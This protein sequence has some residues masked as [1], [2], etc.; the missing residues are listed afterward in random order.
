MKSTTKAP[1]RAK[2]AISPVPMRD[3]RLA[4]R[5]LCFYELPEPERSRA[6]NAWV[7]SAGTPKRNA[8][9]KKRL[10]DFL[11]LMVDIAKKLTPRQR[12][13]ARALGNAILRK[14]SRTRATRSRGAASP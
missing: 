12:A 14:A 1:G 7:N 8:A 11:D 13:A 5:L 9:R 10:R 6:F 4:K 3:R 2:P